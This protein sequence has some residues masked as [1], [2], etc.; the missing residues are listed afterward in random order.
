MHTSNRSCLS[1]MLFVL[2]SSF[3]DIGLAEGAEEFDQLP[4][5]VEYNSEDFMLVSFIPGSIEQ[6]EDFPMPGE[7]YPEIR[8]RFYAGEAGDED[9]GINDLIV[10]EDD[11]T[12][13]VH[14]IPSFGWFNITLRYSENIDPES[15]LVELNGRSIAEFFK[16]HQGGVE[17][18]SVKK[19]K[20]GENNLKFSIAEQ[21]Q[22]SS[23]Q[24]ARRD[25]DGFTIIMEDGMGIQFKGTRGK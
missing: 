10:Y 3:S 20:V 13:A 8:Q 18:L 21:I 15:L 4:R 14:H 19:L 17:T 2:F 5:L 16:P 11:I 24:K 23:G 1:V 25:E 12:G 9:A 22:S 7:N 6:E